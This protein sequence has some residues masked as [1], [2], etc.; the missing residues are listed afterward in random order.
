MDTMKEICSQLLP[1]LE[2]KEKEDNTMSFNEFSAY[3][4]LFIKKEMSDMDPDDIKRLSNSWA[5]RVSLYHKVDIVDPFYNGEDKVMFSLPPM[6]TQVSDITSVSADMGRVADYFA[7]TL[8]R[9]TRFN[10]EMNESSKMMQAAIL[11]AQK[12]NIAE[13]GKSVKEFIELNSKITGE[14]TELVAIDSEESTD[15]YVWE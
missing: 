1:E 8:I 5:S 15:E 7:D 9:D 11:L 2:A 4:P 13:I 6:F 3:S 10:G 12:K 14:E